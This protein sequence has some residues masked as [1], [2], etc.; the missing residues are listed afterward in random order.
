MSWQS[1]IAPSISWGKTHLVSL[2]RSLLVLALSLAAASAQVA[3]GPPIAPGLPADKESYL[4]QRRQLTQ[5]DADGRFDATTRLST[6]EQR[7]DARLVALRKQLIKQYRDEKRFPPSEPFHAVKDEI[8]KT[9]L[10][11]MLRDMPKGG[12]LH[13]HTSSTAPA[14]WI[15]EKGIREPGCHVCWPDDRGEAIRGQL[16]FFRPGKAPPGYQPVL[17]VLE[18]EGDFPSKLLSLLTIN[19]RDDALTNLQ[20]WTKFNQI[21]QRVERFTGYQPLFEKY[22]TAAFETLL[23]DNVSYVELRAGF[24]NLYDLD[25]KEWD[26]RDRARLMWEL[27]HRIR[28]TQPAFDLKLIYSGGRWVSSEKLWPQIEQAVEL[29]KLWQKHNFV[30]G[31]DIVGEE[32]AGHSTEYFLPDWIK[33]GKYLREQ[34]TTLPLYFHDGESDWPTDHNLYD[35]YLLGTR[36]IGH[37]FNLFRFPALEKRLIAAKV[38]VEVCPISNQQLRYVSDLRIHPASG[39]LNRGVPCVLGND[40]PGIF[41]NDGLTY[42]YWEAVVAWNLDLRAVKQLAFNSLVYSAMTETE[43]R[44]AIDRWQKAWERWIARYAD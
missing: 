7:V 16:G 38:A 24:S 2:S 18:R 29:H 26:Y 12:V 8:R 9:Q 4:R 40:D 22:Y 39:Y 28:E 27:R 43:K 10:Y 14:S 15:V 42:D 23:A 5:I 30:V 34:K 37:G 36:R 32:D 1:W 20:I 17:A 31:F 13:L 35:A 19:A 6:A 11:Q 25:G 33:L 21:F 44:V 41:G 3:Q